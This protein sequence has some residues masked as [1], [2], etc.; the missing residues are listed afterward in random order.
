MIRNL[1]LVNNLFRVWSKPNWMGTSLWFNFKI[2][3]EANWISRNDDGLSREFNAGRA[4][5]V[6]P[7]CAW[8]LFLHRQLEL[9]AIIQLSISSFSRIL[10]SPMFQNKRATHLTNSSSILPDVVVV[11]VSIQSI[12]RSINRQQGL[13][14]VSRCPVYP[15]ETTNTTMPD[16]D[17]Q[18]N[19]DNNNNNNNH[20]DNYAHNSP[21]LIFSSSSYPLFSSIRRTLNLMN[22]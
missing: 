4:S 5:Y 14:N 17:G 11:A 21:L 7:V 12:G 13:F 22:S 20:D 18:S 16:G 6:M 10:I 2:W 3:R 8:W 15:I 19:D 9:V 1:V